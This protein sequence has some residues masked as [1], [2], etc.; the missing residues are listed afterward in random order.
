MINA[1]NMANKWK[2]GVQ[3]GTAAYL[4]GV[5]STEKNPIQLAIDAAP[6]WAQKVQEAAANGSY[7]AG[8]AGMTK[9]DWQAAAKNG[10]SKFAGSAQA[11][12]TN[13]MRYA[14]AAAPV[15]A[16]ISR[17]VASMPNLTE[18]DADARMLAASHMARER[19][20]NLGRRR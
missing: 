19:L 12:M 18:A 15:L 11:G 6:K 16:E 17:E 9:S 7:A 10:A 2:A 14:S 5:S 20:K 1:T 3:N 8:F 4:D 13:F